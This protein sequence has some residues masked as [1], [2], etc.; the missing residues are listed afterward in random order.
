MWIWKNKL[1]LRPDFFLLPCF[2]F[3]QGQFP[4]WQFLLAAAAHEAGHLFCLQLFRV[5]VKSICLTAFGAEIHASLLSLSYPQEIATAFSGPFVNLLL[6]SFSARFRE[7]YLFAG[8]NLLLALLN[9]LPITGLDG[10]RVLELVLCWLWDPVRGEQVSR[11][12]GKIVPLL[13]LWAALWLCRRSG[14]NFLLLLAALG[15]LFA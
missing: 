2:F 12:L 7:G 4:L 3:L 11:V 8:I 10:G 1:Y 13:F 5:P 9:L 14:G 15:L 6:A